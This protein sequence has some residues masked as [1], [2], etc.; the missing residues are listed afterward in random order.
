MSQPAPPSLTV[1]TDGSQRTFAP[2]HDVVIG[3]DLRADVRVANPLV[4]RA[5]IVLRFDQ[6]QGR[7]VAFDN[8]SLNG[9]FVDSRRVPS[10]DVRDGQ[11]INLGNPD[12]PKL[13][14]EVGRHEGAVGRPPQTTSVK[15]QPGPA[16]PSGRVQA[17]QPLSSGP[18][19][20]A[21]PPRYPA[22]P[23]SGPQVQAAPPVYPPGPP[24]SP[25]VQA[26]PPVYPP[27]PPS[28]PQV[29]AA[30]PVYPP[31]P[32]SSPQVHAAPPV[33]PPSESQQPAPASPH[34]QMATQIRQ[35]VPPR[36][37]AQ[38]PVTGM[39]KILRG[40][41]AAAPAGAITVGRATD[42][43][44]VIP[45]VLASRHHA[46][47]VPTQSGTEIRDERSIN[48]TFV[49]GNRVDRAL[50]GDNDVV[51]IGNVD[52]V[53][54]GGTLVRRTETE[55]DTRTGGLEVR[56]ISLE[57]EKK[58]LLDNISLSARP[59]M[60]TAVIGPSGAGKST[61][62]KVVVGT[63]NPTHGRVL[64]EG[65]D[66]HAEYASL[67][68]RIGMV[69]QDDVVHGQLTIN[70]ALGYAAELRLP[71]DTTKADRRQVINQ[72]LEELELTV[73]AD[74]RVDKLSGGQRKRASVAMELLTG[75][76]LLVLDEPTSGLDPA[77][78][79]QVMTM[80]R[81]LADAGRTVLVV[82]HSLTYL[83]VCDQV[84]LLAPGGK[85]AFCGPPSEIGP[86]LGTTNWA[87]IF[88]TVAKDPEG[89]KLRY[90]E[91]YPTPAALPE[92]EKPV[93]LGKPVH[94]SLFR[95][96]STIARRQVRLVVSDRGYFIFLM[97]L[98]FIM[99]SLSMSVPHYVGL[100]QVQTTEIPGLGLSA[101]GNAPNEPNQILVL[102]NVGAIF[103]GTALT[104]R[105]LIG[106][107]AIFLREQ[108]VG[109]STSAY[110]LAKMVV[111]S[112]FAV[113]QAGIVIVIT[114]L[115]VGWGPGAV[116]SGAVLNRNL[117]MFVDVAFTCVA[118]AMVGLALSAL[119]RSNEQIMPLL[120]VA[121]MSQLVFS[122]GMIPVTGSP[123]DVLAKL[124]PAR[125][126]FAASASTVDLVRLVPGPVTPKDRFW[127]HMPKWWLI[128]MAMLAVIS[129]AY[130]TF[131]RWRIRLKG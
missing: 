27:G 40:G 69:P 1:R 91:R 35:P 98:P 8:G 24:S 44:I 109:L 92:G 59:G 122:G 15:L 75:P 56:G 70:Q 116:T 115:L 67:R 51:T 81:Q 20:H 60:L 102:L 85:I 5:H 112:V 111:F 80:L 121:I 39:V 53:F 6:D 93:D 28:S 38:N 30:P 14:F 108:A 2:G 119:A 113:L 57:I 58:T 25:Q 90:L 64:F 79:R 100:G 46:T 21:A 101:T 77:L 48:G 9:I 10:V 12:G 65:H 66:I 105:A 3:R 52:L 120:V 95:Q 37:G 31:G 17:P 54:K 76:S 26:A 124:T 61:L 43:D 34:Y 41:G 88:S 73:H 110:L 74:K 107:R 125:W 94:T 18:Q 103:I 130:A 13:T 78:D 33:Y 72:V 32:P 29:H 4:S 36:G 42:N 131:V 118:A 126:G 62:S 114:I 7:W 87:D 97:V 45:D 127:G 71:P 68:S 84:L 123:L 129:V 22:G 99:G 82:T 50:L 117:E 23:P 55:A 19:V 128:D 49:N 89:A 86:E 106:E 11:S 63:T 83:D 96:F 47:L 16:G 104:I